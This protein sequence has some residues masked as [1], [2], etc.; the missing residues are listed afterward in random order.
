MLQTDNQIKIKKSILHSL[1]ATTTKCSLAWCS[2]RVDDVVSRPQAAGIS[3]CLAQV[4]CCKSQ[5]G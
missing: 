1:Y 3:C 4:S 5:S 2:E